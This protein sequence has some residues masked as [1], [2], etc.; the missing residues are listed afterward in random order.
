[1]RYDVVI[2]GSGLGGLEC[3]YLLA[4]AGR[5]V[6]VLEQGNC[7]GG[8]L[9]S[10]SHH[11]ITFDTGFHYV[12]GLDEGQRLHQVF[13][14]MGLMKLPWVRMDRSGFDR[15]V[16]GKEEF[17]YAEGYAEFARRMSDYFPA[18]RQ[19]IA[20]YVELLRQSAR[21]ELAQL[22]PAASSLSPLPSFM[23]QSAWGYLRQHFRSQLAIDVLG[24]TSIKMGLNREKMT[25]FTLLHGN[26]SYIE[27]SWRLQGSGSLIVD[28]LCAGIK[29]QG[30]EVV[31]RARVEE[32]HGANGRIQAAKC[33]NGEVVE[34]NLFISDLHPW[35]TLQ[36]LEPTGLTKRAYGSRLR[37]I[38]NSPGVVT[39][40]LA[41]KPYTYRYHPFNRY[42]YTHE[43][44]WSSGGA[45]GK[46]DRMMISCRVPENSGGYLQQID[47]L[48]P[49]EWTYW[50]QWSDRP[51]RH[52]GNKYVTQKQL[53][54]EECIAM[55]SRWFPELRSA[56]RSLV[57]T[58]LTW[59]HYTRSPEGSAFG[60][61]R[62]CR[63]PLLT[64]L[65]VR[66]PV[67]NLLLTGQSLMMHGVYGVTMTS[68]FTCAEVLGKERIWDIVKRTDY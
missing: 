59:N 42:V 1:M 33:S 7:P 44:I 15:V 68:L 48:V 58:P 4:R 37:G 35:L 10:Y 2:I 3:A 56:S 29:A 40:S 17:C 51:V 32:L 62:D 26:S 24:G 38:P 13:D 52:R 21:E 31:C 9:Q 46:I 12:G 43:D 65:S 54:A 20:D 23:E 25:L 14:Y 22:N 30:G 60:L 45:L 5:S 27:S 55:A 11:G 18:E 63:N 36:L 34:G 47:L 66:T 39:V 50:S 53:L 67:P 41:L 49:T 16:I 57:S 28:T 6:L 8:C 61:Q 64:L 19:A